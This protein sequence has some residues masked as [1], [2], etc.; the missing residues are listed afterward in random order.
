MELEKEKGIYTKD[1]SVMSDHCFSLENILR[2]PVFRAVTLRE[3]ENTMTV[4]KATIGAI[5]AQDE[6]I[7]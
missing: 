1:S 2:L 7:A 3:S 5:N 6:I 4:N